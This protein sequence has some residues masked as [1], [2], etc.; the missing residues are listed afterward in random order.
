MRPSELV[1]TN[2][3]KQAPPFDSN[4]IKSD[5]DH[6]LAA[7][8]AAMP[9]GVN[10]TCTLS[11]AVAQDHMQCFQTLCTMACPE[12]W[13]SCWHAVLTDGNFDS[14]DQWECVIFHYLYCFTKELPASN[15][16]SL[17]GITNFWP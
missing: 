11:V 5:S 1:T 14:R 8:I 15:I 9:K 17:H 10:I 3:A 4:P 7:L 6:R 2:A 16:L 13:K 12:E